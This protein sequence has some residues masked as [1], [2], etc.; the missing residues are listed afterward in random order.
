M[1]FTH[2]I[3]ETYSA[4]GVAVSQQTEQSADGEDNRD[5]EVALD[6]S[7]LLVNIPIDITELKG[8]L[9][10][11]DQDLTLEINH[12]TTPD[13]TINLTANVPIIWH[14]NSV[15]ANPLDQDVTTI[16]ITNGSG[17]ATTLKIRVLQD[18]TP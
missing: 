15:H 9:L 5:I 13:Q 10:L 8:F 6:A 11:A 16:Y 7:D 2:T 18:S 3:I 4:G 1:A 17:V 14:A 12:A